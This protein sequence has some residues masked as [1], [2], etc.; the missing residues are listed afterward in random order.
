[1]MRSHIPAPATEPFTGQEKVMTEER[2]S[3]LPIMREDIIK[4]LTGK[5]LFQYLHA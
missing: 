1:M 4:S 5:S 3:P 2:L